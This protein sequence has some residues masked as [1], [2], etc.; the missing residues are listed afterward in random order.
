MT[1]LKGVSRL[2]CWGDVPTTKTFSNSAVL[3]GMDIPAWSTGSSSWDKAI[4]PR[5]RA[6]VRS[7]VCSKC[8]E[9]VKNRP[10]AAMPT[11]LKMTTAIRTSTRVKP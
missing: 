8:L 3:F 1:D 11:M 9:K 6:A 7:F 10:V 2:I 4:S 5:W